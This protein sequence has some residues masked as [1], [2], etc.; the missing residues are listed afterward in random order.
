MVNSENLRIILVLLAPPCPCWEK[1][2]RVDYRSWDVA[3][4]RKRRLVVP[5]VSGEKGLGDERYHRP[6]LY[7]TIMAWAGFF[8]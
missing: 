8:L 5:F 3:A 1:G 7:F 6:N 4:P 2:I